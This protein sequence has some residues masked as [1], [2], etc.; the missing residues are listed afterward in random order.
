MSIIVTVA[1]A[2]VI[3]I[4]IAAPVGPIGLLCIKKTLELGIVGAIAVGLGAALADSIYGLIAGAG[5]TAVSIFLF[6]IMHYLKIFGGILLLTLGAKECLSNQQ[7]ATI[8]LPKINLSR[9]ALTT[10]MLTLSNPLTILSF[11][12]VF[13]A[14]GSEH[15]SLDDTAWILI[16]VFL[17]SMSWW[18]FLGYIVSRSHKILPKTWIEKI[19]YISAFILIA[20]GAWALFDGIRE[21]ATFL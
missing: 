18:L 5:L 8:E 12:G 7:K 15:F 1:E 10:F 20:F 14:I 16:G 2:W 13:T 21:F 4:A 17:G 11:A 3:G 19:R 6:G 9:L